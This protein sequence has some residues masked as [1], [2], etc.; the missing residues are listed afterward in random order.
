MKNK[1]SFFFT[2]LVF[3]FSVSPSPCFAANDIKYQLYKNYENYGILVFPTH[4]SFAELG[5]YINSIGFEPVESGKAVMRYGSKG[6]NSTYM[7]PQKV[8]KKYAMEKFIII[9]VLQDHGLMIGIYEPEWG[10][11][12]PNTKF[13]LEHIKKNIQK[14]LNIFR[15]ANQKKEVFRELQYP[16]YR[17]LIPHS[18]FNYP[19]LAAE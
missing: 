3:V 6:E 16:A 17:S 13:L 1:S 19:Q 9:Q 2:L 5:S 8:Q 7:M 4:I 12:I 11:T 14:T 10:L 18:G 15:G